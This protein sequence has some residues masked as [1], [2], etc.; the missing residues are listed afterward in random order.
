MENKTNGIWGW[1]LMRLIVLSVLV[2]FGIIIFLQGW[3]EEGLRTL[4]VWSA[5]I[6]LLCF[7]LAFGARAI[8][9]WLRRSIS[10]WL[11]MN[12]R[13]L[14]VSF[15]IIHLIHLS[16]LGLMQ[17]NFHP[18][19]TERSF[20]SFIPGG[21]AYIFVLLLLI[22]SFDQFAKLLTKGQWKKLH[23]YGAMWIWLIFTLRYTIGFVGGEY[24]TGLFLFVLLG[25]MALRIRAR[26][27]QPATS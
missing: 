21:I 24:W 19:F 7:I 14:G 12:R 22:T 2:L 27:I 23:L 13:Y 9:L 8:H 4:I 6:G 11:M 20:V 10:Y 16:F 25:V 18:V 3:N 5:R 17:Y 26:F 15:A 1:Q